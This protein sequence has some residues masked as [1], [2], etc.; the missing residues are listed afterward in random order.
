MNEEL[1][2]A[3]RA[4]LDFVRYEIEVKRCPPTRSDVARFFGWRSAN[5]AEE[6]LRAIERK[7]Y[8]TIE[9]GVSRGIRLA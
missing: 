2:D 6:H 9:R 1:T 4:V 5:A 7:G 3:Q 8:I